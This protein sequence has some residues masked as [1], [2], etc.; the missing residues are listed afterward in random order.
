MCV[1][2]A[3]LWAW[4]GLPGLG[5]P[6][7][8]RMTSPR[9]FAEKIALHNQKQAEGTA[10]FEQVMRDVHK[11]TKVRREMREESRGVWNVVGAPRP[12]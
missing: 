11:A 9:K 7:V 2:L 3:L 12:S 6:V 4:P 1:C 8:T 10:E 5:L